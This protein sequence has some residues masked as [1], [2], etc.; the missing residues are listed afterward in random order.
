MSRR[1]ETGLNARDRS[2]FTMKPG[3][4]LHILARDPRCNLIPLAA[5]IADLAAEFAEAAGAKGIDLCVPR[6]AGAMFSRR[7]LLRGMLRNLLRTRSITPRRVE[8]CWRVLARAE[9]AATRLGV[10]LAE[11]AEALHRRLEEIHEQA[12]RG[13]Q[14]RQSGRGFQTVE[15]AIADSAAHDIDHDLSVLAAVRGRERD[16][17]DRGERPRHSS[18]PPTPGRSCD[19]GGS[20]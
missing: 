6:A 7:V 1:C 19:R 15:A 10:M 12:H 4:S 14:S 17:L 5:L 18:A 8:A 3:A 20:A 11:L 9:D 13:I 16:A 2:M